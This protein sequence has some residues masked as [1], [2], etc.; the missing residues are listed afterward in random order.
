MWRTG[1][2][3]RG[4]RRAGRGGEHGPSGGRSGGVNDRLG[5]GLGRWRRLGAGGDDQEEKA[6]DNNAHAPIL[7]AP[8]AADPSRRHVSGDDARPAK[9]KRP[10]RRAIPQFRGL[11]N[12]RLQRVGWGCRYSAPARRRPP[13]RRFRR[14][15]PSSGRR[16]F[17]AKPRSRQQKNRE[18]ARST[19]GCSAARRRSSPGVRRRR[20]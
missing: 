16:R 20:R 19:F 6:D 7:P 10:G 8:D 14:P 17:L 4:L 2:G 13:D 3:G 1:G 18:E 15:C 11:G 12:C 5:R 9:S